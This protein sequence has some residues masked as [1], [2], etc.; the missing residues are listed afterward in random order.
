MST[1]LCTAS[2]RHRVV[3]LTAHQRHGG[4]LQADVKCTMAAHPPFD[5]TGQALLRWLAP[6]RRSTAQ[7]AYCLPLLPFGPDG[8]QQGSLARGPAFNTA[9][10]R[11]TLDCEA[12]R[13][14]LYPSMAD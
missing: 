9:R 13:Q 11:Q 14:G 1:P 6:V 5:N 8:V 7:Q 12:L 4:R 2:R 3:V 10:L